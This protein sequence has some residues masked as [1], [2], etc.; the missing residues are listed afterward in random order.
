MDI[1]RRA[2]NRWRRT[3]ACFYTQTITLAIVILWLTTLRK[4]RLHLKFFFVKFSFHFKI[5]KLFL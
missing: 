4:V 1:L 3:V 2:V 5:L